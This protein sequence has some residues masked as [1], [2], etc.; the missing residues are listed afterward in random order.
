MVIVFQLVPNGQDVDEKA[1]GDLMQRDIARTPERN[2][3]LTH[4]KG[5]CPICEK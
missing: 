4:K 2:Q 5:Y 1:G 3:E